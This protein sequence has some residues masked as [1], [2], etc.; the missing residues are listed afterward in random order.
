MIFYYWLYLG[1]VLCKNTALRLLTLQYHDLSHDSTRHN[2][3]IM[4][5]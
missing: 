2:A 1:T 5:I 3:V 4:S